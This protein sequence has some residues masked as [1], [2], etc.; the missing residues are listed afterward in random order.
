[1][2]L[3]LIFFS[4]LFFSCSFNKDNKIDLDILKKQGEKIDIFESKNLFDKEINTNLTLQLNQTLLNKK[5]HYEHFS[6]NNFYDHFFYEGKFDDVFIKNIGDYL[7]KKN[8][9]GSLLASENFIFFSDQKGTIY[10]FDL[11]SQKII[12]DLKI[13]DNT[14]NSYPKNIALFLNQDVLYGTDNLGFVYSIDVNTG[15]IIWLQNYGV[16]FASH[17]N[18][19][20]DVLYV[21]NQNSRLYA[22]NASTGQKIWSFEALSGLVKPSRSSNI[23]INDNKLIFSNDL[24]DL[25]V[26]DLKQQT[27]LW[28]INIFS[29]NRIFNNFFL[30]ISN[31]LIDKNNVYISSNGGDLL[32]FNIEN[33]DINWSKKISSIQ[34]HVISDKYLFV[35]TEDGFIIAFNKLDGNILWSL[36]LAKF[37]ID[38][39]NKNK[40]YYGLILASSNLYV[41]SSIGE[42]YKISANNGKYISHKKIA[43]ELSRAPI[44]VNNKM[45]IL[46]HSSELIIIN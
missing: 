35:L 3:I 27:V 6:S 16:P 1:M 23:S 15:K 39:N 4:I 42:I 34:N 13:H 44:I 24:G 45:L 31:I 8:D 32:N 40:D 7:D 5:W 14:Y 21:V 28:S 37:S 43:S 30:K 41:A 29:T 10:K 17:L 18:F 46:N 11:N 22:F 25:T 19:Y 38:K 36:N 12:W 2:K 26:V 9:S 33:G 20:Q